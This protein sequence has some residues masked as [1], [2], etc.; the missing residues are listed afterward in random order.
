MRTKLSVATMALLLFSP[1]LSYAGKGST[2]GLPP[3]P[4]PAN[5]PQTPQKINLGK[6]LFFDTSLSKDGKVA[7]ASCH[8]PNKGFADGK[9]VGVGIDGKQGTRNTPSVVNAVFYNSMFWD[10]RR[11]TLEKQALDPLT[12]PV[13]HG[14]GNIEEVLNRVRSTERYVTRF[15]DVFGVQP[16]QVKAEHV[17]KA[18]AAYERTLVSGNSPFDRYQYKGIKSAMSPSA[19]RGLKVFKGKGLCVTCH[20]IGPKHATFTDN[21]FHNIG[22]GLD[23]LAGRSS[24]VIGAYLE[25]SARGRKVD[26]SV[27]SDTDVSH[28]GRFAISLNPTDFGN[29]RTPDLRNVALTSPYM[30]DGSLKT[31]E[32]VVRFYGRGGALKDGV[33]NSLQHE[34]IKK[35][36]L[37]SNEQK[38]LVVF[39]KA[40]TSNQMPK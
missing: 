26:T 17:G 35:L 39:M 21:Q 30:H 40:L 38:D 28:L 20:T 10:G 1:G 25:A 23:K 6:L 33:R 13:E 3:V 19:V 36:R 32:E 16:S 34:N 31:L 29:F 27:L 37:T 5:N 22:V 4:I 11:S 7:C 12:N 15:R 24:L 9:P 18:I 8:D 14:F 2:I